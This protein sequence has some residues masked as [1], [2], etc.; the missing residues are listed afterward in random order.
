MTDIN[1]ILAF[2]IGQNQVTNTF[3]ALENQDLT[4]E[5]ENLSDENDDLRRKLAASQNKVQEL[6]RK[7]V[8]ARS[9]VCVWREHAAN[10]EASREAWLEVARTLR[11]EYKI[12]I[13]KESVQ[14]MFT[15]FFNP[16]FKSKIEQL[17]SDP[18]F[19]K[20]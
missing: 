15:D 2:A 7:V 10:L 13:S 12:N 5:N 17:T 1:P 6:D 3:N 4:Y 8:E 18:T 19:R 14:I 16:L 11:S 20:Q 9:L